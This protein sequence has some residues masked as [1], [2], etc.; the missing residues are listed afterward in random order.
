VRPRR[1][2]QLSMGGKTW[3][4]VEV[5]PDT[6]ETLRAS[7]HLKIDVDVRIEGE[8]VRVSGTMDVEYK[9]AVTPPS[10][11]K[12]DKPPVLAAGDKRTVWK[13]KDQH[14]DKNT[15][16]FKRN[17][18]ATWTETNTRGE[19]HTLDEW[20]RNDD[21]V[22]L[23][24]AARNIHLRFYDDRVEIRNRQGSWGVLYQGGWASK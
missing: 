20:Q 13:Y 7:S 17:P 14:R 12:P 23:V 21:Y 8:L 5:Q 18:D 16:V 19:N 11:K 1:G 3:G 6:G 24:E 15:G 10:E 22:L 4:R 2:E 9:P